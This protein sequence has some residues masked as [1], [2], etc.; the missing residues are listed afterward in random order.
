RFTCPDCHGTLWEIAD[1]DL[2]RYRCH[3]GHAFTSDVVLEAQDGESEQLLWT[4]L[5]SHQER[6]ALARRMADK[7]QSNHALASGLRAR[8]HEYDED[9]ELVRKLLKSELSA[10]SADPSSQTDRSSPGG[11]P[12]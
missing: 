2:L 5:R 9:S 11:G 10:W 7:E 1:G 6:A 12:D 8:A 4:L 3:V